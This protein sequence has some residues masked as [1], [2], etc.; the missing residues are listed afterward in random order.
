M[1]KQKEKK[2]QIEKVAALIVDKRKAFY[3][4]AGLV[5]TGVRAF[6][7]GSDMELL[8]YPEDAPYIRFAAYQAL[9]SETFPTGM[10]PDER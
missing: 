3:L 9:L 2:S 6:I 1:S 7:Y 5:E 8:A 10:L 4:S